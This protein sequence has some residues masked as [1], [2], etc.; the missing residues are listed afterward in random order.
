M[1]VAVAP[2][3]AVVVVA[4][5]VAEVGATDRFGPGST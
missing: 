3:A 4:A 2:V 5:V 1:T